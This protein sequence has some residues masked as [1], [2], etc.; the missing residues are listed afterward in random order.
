M[1]NTNL[2]IQF[3]IDWRKTPNVA[4]MDHLRGVKRIGKMI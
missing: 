3:F 2:E 4:Q 1:E